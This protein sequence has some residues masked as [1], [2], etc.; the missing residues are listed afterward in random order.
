[1]SHSLLSCQMFVG[2]VLVVNTEGKYVSG[3]MFFVDL[4]R[5]SLATN[6]EVIF[7]SLWMERRVTAEQMLGWWAFPPYLNPTLHTIWCNRQ[8]CLKPTAIFGRT[9]HFPTCDFQGLFPPYINTKFVSSLEISMVGRLA[10]VFHLGWCIF[11]GYVPFR[12]ASGMN[13]RPINCCWGGPKPPY[14]KVPDCGPVVSALDCFVGDVCFVVWCSRW[15][16]GSQFRPPKMVVVSCLNKWI[17]RCL[18]G[19]WRTCLFCSWSLVFGPRKNLKQVLGCW[20]MDRKRKN[21]GI[22]ILRL[23]TITTRITTCFTCL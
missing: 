8:S 9:C 18:E 14:A 2:W 21:D 15:S 11:R 23:V 4:K 10:L 5:L 3:H 20:K 17:S 6:P 1:M 19:W 13:Y 22:L 16:H 12:E 7:Y